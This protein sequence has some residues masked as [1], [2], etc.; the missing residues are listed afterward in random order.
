MLTLILALILLVLS[1]GTVEYEAVLK[2][3]L[4]GLFVGRVLG[5]AVEVSLVRYRPG[6]VYILAR[7]W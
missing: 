3:D 4:G 6:R 1:G 2:A 7:A 5:R